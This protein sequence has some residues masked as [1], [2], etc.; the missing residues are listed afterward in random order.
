[1]KIIKVYLFFSTFVCLSLMA[2]LRGS[3]DPDYSNYLNIYNSSL[4]DLSINIEPFYIYLNQ[5][6]K[7]NDVPFVF[8]I[9]FI[10]LVAVNIKGYSIYRIAKYPFLS[11]I[12]YSFTIYILFD[13]I[14]IRQGLALAFIML[15]F[16]YLDKNKFASIM[17]LLFAS[18]FHFSAI[19]VLPFVFLCFKQHE[20]YLLFILYLALISLSILKIEIPIYSLLVNFNVLPAFLSNKLETY[21]SYNQESFLSIKQYI[22][23]FIGIIV[24]IYYKENKLIKMMCLF[25]LYGCI[26]SVIL[27]SVGDIAYRIK[28]YFLF[29]EIFFIP[30][31]FMGMYNKIKIKD[32]NKSLLF[33][34]YVISIFTIATLY[35]IPGFNFIENIYE[36]GNSLVF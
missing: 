26:L 21:S 4:N 20:K 17:L 27:S 14:A 36:R 29:S 10:S 33:L 25:Y 7:M 23:T 1:M 34:F 22:V 19:I 8:L 11:V 5:I 31:F 18:L 35:I 3:G 16:L 28:W 30:V 24:Y 15:S 6:F 9:F 12:I 2:G 13:L 32:N